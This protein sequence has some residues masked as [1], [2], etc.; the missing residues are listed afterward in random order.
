M[1]DRQQPFRL[2]LNLVIYIA[3]SMYPGNLKHS[4]GDRRSEIARKGPDGMCRQS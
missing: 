4:K 2:F 3:D 1:Q